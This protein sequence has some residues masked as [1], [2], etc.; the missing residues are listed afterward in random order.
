MRTTVKEQVR[1]TEGKSTFL[2]QGTN[3][4]CKGPEAAAGLG[5]Q[6]QL[7]DL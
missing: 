5:A 6:G 1:D 7:L 3:W 4:M 2:C